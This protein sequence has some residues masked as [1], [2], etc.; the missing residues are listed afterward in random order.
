MQVTVNETKPQF[1]KCV[2]F[3]WFFTGTAKYSSLERTVAPFQGER[4]DFAVPMVCRYRESGLHYEIFESRLLGMAMNYLC[5]LPLKDRP[6]FMGA[7]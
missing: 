3:D 4:H 7:A 1:H 2:E 5:A 6:V